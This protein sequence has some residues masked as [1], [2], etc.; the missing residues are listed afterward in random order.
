[1][2]WCVKL[3]VL[4]GLV[5]ALSTPG[6][7]QFIEKTTG[8][9]PSVSVIIISTIGSVIGVSVCL[10]FCIFCYCFNKKRPYGLP[11]SRHGVQD[12]YTEQHHRDYTIQPQQIILHTAR[13]TTFDL[14]KATLHSGTEPPLYHEAINIESI[15]L[16][17]TELPPPPYS[18]TVRTDLHVNVNNKR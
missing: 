6:R 10:A 1:M 13:L 4:A 18:S 14:P 12:L 8:T 3:C 11:T 9:S 2:S 7:C 15:Q 17:T 5:C 16:P